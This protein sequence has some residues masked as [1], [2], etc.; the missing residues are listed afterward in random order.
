MGDFYS[1]G[2][3][4]THPY[5]SGIFFGQLS[6]EQLRQM[7]PELTEQE[8]QALSAKHFYEPMASLTPEHEAA[9]AA[10]PLSPDECF[11]PGDI[12]AILLDKRSTAAENGYGVLPNGVGYAA[13]KIE[14]EGITDEMIKKYREEFAHDGP[15]TLFYKIWF[16]GMHL[17]HYENGVAENF[18]WG[19]LNLEMEM[20]NFTFRHL[21]ICKED[22]PVRDPDCI[23]LLGIYGRG[24]QI[25]Y[26]E[27]PPVYT[28]MV[29][30]TRQTS[31][32][33]ELRVRYWSGI[34]FGPDGSLEF[35]V[36]PDHGQ[37]CEQMRLMMEHCMREYS[38]ELK[39]IK[40]FW[41]MATEATIQ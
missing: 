13:I 37:T 4:M 30:H 6:Y 28:C 19:M 38:N 31:A 9:I 35:H 20:E 10:P 40:E 36:N 17:L 34:A 12:G 26:P 14:Q 25:A 22:I 39:L 5:T 16:P 29:Q 24:W 15:R 41:N 32:G 27:K 7:T 11:L 21:G 8:K 33:R 2:R 3:E 23:C 1:T 18:G